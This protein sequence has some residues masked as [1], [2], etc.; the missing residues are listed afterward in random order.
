MSAESNATAP[1]TADPALPP[2][3]SASNS[4]DLSSS[5]L[6]VNPAMPG[7]E[8]SG[9]GPKRQVDVPSVP[10]EVKSLLDRA[11]STLVRL[12]KLLKAPGG[13][14]SF[15]STTNYALYIL[16]HLHTTAPTRAQLLIKLNSFLGRAAP[17]VAPGAVAPSAPTSPILP[18]ALTLGDTRTTLRLTGLIPLYVLLK[19]LLKS[20]D[21]DRISYTIKLAQVASYIVFQALENVFHLTNKTVVNANWTNARFARVGGHA[22]L[23]TWSCR[24]WLCGISCDFLRLFREA[25]LGRQTGRYERMNADEKREADRKWWSEFFVAAS[26]YPMALQ[27]AVEGGIGLNMGMIGLCGFMANLGNFAKAWQ[28]T[29]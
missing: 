20:S 5:H 18:L 6:P 7:S 16:A 2:T 4:S 22:K 11:D 25:Q 21:P 24:A 23:M 1:V 28:A 15:L 17:K 8:K 3:D 26:W 14:A 13:L 19:S 10:N 9:S 12:N 27:Y 29:K